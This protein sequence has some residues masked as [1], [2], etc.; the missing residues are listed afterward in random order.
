MFVRFEEHGEL[1]SITVKDSS[2]TIP[3]R[4]PN[5]SV[6]PSRNLRAA[7][8]EIAYRVRDPG[9]GNF[10]EKSLIGIMRLPIARGMKMVF[11]DRGRVVSEL[12]A[13]PIHKIQ[14][15]RSKNETRQ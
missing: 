14:L 5:G 3:K 1:Y 15:R 7:M 12:S 6:S 13:N 9:T 4:L 8:C 10:V 2:I 11:S